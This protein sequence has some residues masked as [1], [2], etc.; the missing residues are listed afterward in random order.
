MNTLKHI[1]LGIFIAGTLLFAS[2]TAQGQWLNKVKDKAND[3]AKQAT[4]TTETKNITESEA[5]QA[6]RDALDNGAKNTVNIV[7]VADGYFHPKASQ[8]SPP[9]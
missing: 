4:N 1:N 7:S 8:Q 2:C 3:V 9:L 5:A 6:L